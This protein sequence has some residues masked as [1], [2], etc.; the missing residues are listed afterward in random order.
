MR[1]ARETA[2]LAMLGGSLVVL[3][4]YRKLLATTRKLEFL[5]ECVKQHDMGLEYLTQQLEALREGDE[6]KNLSPPAS[7]QHSCSLQKLYGSSKSSPML[8]P[9]AGNAGAGAAPAHAPRITAA[10]A[11]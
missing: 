3:F 7:T 11:E 5:S 4:L 1:S 2:A 10:P 9:I 6:C 8:I